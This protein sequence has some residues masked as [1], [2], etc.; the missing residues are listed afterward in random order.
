VRRAVAAGRDLTRRQD[1]LL[2]GL[3]LCRACTAQV[4]LSGR[5]GTYLA[6]V[7][8][9]V[10]A[11][12]W[13]QALEAAAPSADWAACARWTART[14]F[15]DETV[16]ALLD[17][18]DG[19]SKWEPGRRAAMIAWQQLWD[20][21]DAAQARAR[22]AAGPPGL[23]A[24]AAAACA[25]V[26]AQQD[27]VLE[28]E[29]IAAISAPPQ[30]R[31]QPTRAPGWGAASRAWA[32]TI[33]LDADPAAARAA[34]ADAVEQLYATAQVRDLAL[35]P[36]VPSCRGDEFTSLAQWAHA[37]YRAVRLAVACRWY[38]RLEAALAEVHQEADEVTGR[39]PEVH[40]PRSRGA[41]EGLSGLSAVLIGRSAPPVEDGA[42][43]GDVPPGQ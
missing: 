12:A 18:L 8:H 31:N 25:L 33:C 24:H 20:R 1:G 13:T 19:D 11:R 9:I 29:L 3:E 21:A 39:G 23:R 41:R 37:G 5:A 22:L 17:A 26:A 35:L 15:D 2:A 36:P 27:T 16:L 38:R 43:C 32:Q 10:A 40:K 30:R 28:N 42:G 4:Q 7:G 6:I 34:L 14:P